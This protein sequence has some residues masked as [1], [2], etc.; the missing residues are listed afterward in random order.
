MR[1]V[2]VCGSRNEQGQTARAVAAMLDGVRDG[3]W[4][5]AIIHL[6]Q[7]SLERC[8]QCELDGWGLCRSEGRC[9]IEDDFDKVA[10]AI[11]DADVV[12]FATPVY[13]ADLSESLRELLCRLRRVAFFAADHAGVQGKPAAGLCVAGGRGGGA[14]Q[15]CATLTA[16]LQT[17]GFDVIDML[18]VRRQNLEARLP[19][20][21]RVGRW[22]TIQ[23]TTS[24]ETK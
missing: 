24:G 13:F 2:V 21:R 20:L 17:C 12:V 16:I 4:D 7:L 10:R 9:I 22:L 1:V 18:P 14:P 3:G 15:C 19:D 8:R 6:P 5:G 11:R 23:A